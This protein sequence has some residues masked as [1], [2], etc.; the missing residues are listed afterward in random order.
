MICFRNPL[1]LYEPE[2]KGSPPSPRHM[3]VMN[4]N[5]HFGMITLFGGKDQYHIFNDLY[6]IDIINFNWIKVDLFFQDS[7]NGRIG[8]CS[9]IIDDKLY[10]FG[11]CDNSGKLLPADVMSIELNLYKNKKYS[12]IYKFNKNILNDNPENKMAKQ[13][14]KKLK[15]GEGA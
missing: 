7:I 10:I 13:I 8:H 1:I 5:K 12:E 15:Y 11:G 2:I 14:L 9:E 4:F 3:S 6:I